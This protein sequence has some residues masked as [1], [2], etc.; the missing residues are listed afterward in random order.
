MPIMGNC[1][2]SK[3]K[4]TRQAAPAKQP[5][6]LAQLLKNVGN[7]ERD[8]DAKV[9]MLSFEYHYNSNMNQ[10]E[11][12]ENLS[13][14]E[15]DRI[16]MRSNGEQSENPS[17]LK[18]PDLLRRQNGVSEEREETEEA[19]QY[20]DETDCVEGGASD[21]AE[22]ENEQEDVQWKSSNWKLS[23]EEQLNINDS[24]FTVESRLV[25]DF[26]YTHFNRG[27]KQ[28]L[29]DTHDTTSPNSGD[30][31]S[32]LGLKLGLLFGDYSSET[33]EA[34]AE[35]DTKIDGTQGGFYA[36]VVLRSRMERDI[37]SLKLLEAEQ[38]YDGSVF[39]MALQRKKCKAELNR[40]ISLM[41][42]I[43][44]V[45]R[46]FNGKVTPDGAYFSLNWLKIN[47]EANMAMLQTIDVIMMADKLAKRF[48]R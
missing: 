26:T 33:Q 30:I 15:H 20:L 36:P 40:D 45:K 1:I 38:A 29:D 35:E 46:T 22:C 28:L 39:D 48:C 17:V 6:T 37:A 44:I 27:V 12:T 32:S 13:L 3:E 9:E 23:Q 8:D 10:R 43:D 2:S 4:P 47:C 14:A 18:K 16:L 25:R 21:H 31:L 41:R 7:N 5:S 42:Y 24:S 11:M 19:I 34:Q